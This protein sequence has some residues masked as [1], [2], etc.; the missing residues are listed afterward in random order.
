ML[1]LSA[2]FKDLNNAQ[3]LIPIISTFI[4]PPGH[5]RQWKNLENTCGL[6][7]LVVS[8][9]KQLE[10]VILVS[11]H[12]CPLWTVTKAHEQNCHGSRK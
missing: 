6:P 2:M 8:Q 12:H 4:F 9:Y 5:C 11:H 10:D 7:Q 3:I 1:E